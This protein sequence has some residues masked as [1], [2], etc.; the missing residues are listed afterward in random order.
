[1]PRPEKQL[2][3]DASPRD[4]FGHEARHW[5]K[6]RGYTAAALGPLVQVSQSLLEKVEKGT[7]TCRRDLAERLD[8]V[9]ETGGVLTRAWGMVYGEPENRHAETEKSPHGA[10]RGTVRASQGRILSRDISSPPGSPDLD[11][12]AFLATSSF[13]AVASIDLAA[14][15]APAT[16]P[17]LPARIR[18]M[19]VAQIVSVS[20]DIHRRDNAHG[21]G[22]LVGVLAGRAMQWAVSLLPV[23]CPEPLQ[24]RLYTAVAQ[25]GIVVGASHFDA[26]AHDD[27]RVAFKIAADCAEEARDWHLRAKV[28]SFL[29]RQAIWIGDPDTGLTQAEKGLVRADRLTPT[30]HAMLHSARA[31]AFAKMGDVAGTLA[32]VGA[33]D[34]A[35]AKSNPADDP[36]W[37]AY[38]NAA[39]HHG[40]TAHAWFDLA[41]LKDQDPGQAQRRFEIAIA[42]HDDGYARSRAISGTKLASLLMAKGDPQQAAVIGHRALDDAGGLTSQRA[43]D[44]L[45][46]LG[47]FTARHRRLPEGPYLRERISATLQA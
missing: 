35:F 34:D 44:D 46:E 45:R 28:Y 32:A 24:P 13:A 1:M 30:I 7:A 10:T 47:R 33:A 43:A 39:Q 22:G 41:I 2:D 12:R 26:Y 36:P 5:R 8:E 18:A 6:E 15:V 19:D 25:L 20:D 9:L 38:Y 40:D 3:P 29:A 4:W 23:P 11:R 27:A 37:M 16:P 21:G 42:G 14:L 17:R 31:R